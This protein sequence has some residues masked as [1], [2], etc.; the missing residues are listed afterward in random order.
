MRFAFMLAEKASFPIAFMA[1][2][3]EV[4]RAGYYAWR[5]RSESQRSK[6]NRK[7]SRVSGYA[8]A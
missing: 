8:A 6:E 3:L 7:R 5:K 2:H 4:S 1:R